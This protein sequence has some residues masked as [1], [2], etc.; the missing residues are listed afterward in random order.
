MAANGML[1]HVA[2]IMDLALTIVHDADHLQSALDDLADAD[3]VLI[4]TPG[5]GGK[6]SSMMAE[7]RAL[8]HLAK[9]HET[10]LV[11]NATLRDDILAAGVKHFLP[12]DP[13]KL[14]FTHMDEYGRSET[15]ANLLRQSGLPSAF[16]GD[17]IDLI[18]HLQEMTVGKL[19]GFGPSDASPR[20]RLS[21]LP[22]TRQRRPTALTSDD[23]SGDSIHYV[24][25]RNSELFHQPT[26]RSVKGIDTHHITAFNS[27]E[28]AMQTG[29]K[30]RR[31]C[32]DTD[33]I[34]K[35]VTAASGHQHAHAI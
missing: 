14:L 3:V 13:D 31:A 24:A 11:L 29:L 30:P 23:F 18:D 28:H 9:P 12:L 35:S 34:I 8:L 17:G 19:V 20:G 32:C 22:T 16:Y 25:N 5:I 2:Q 33:A 4:D 15:V 10:H 26:C 27:I 6:D 21:V 1:D 7:V